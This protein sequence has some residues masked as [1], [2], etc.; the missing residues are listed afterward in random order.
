M[1]G[2]DRRLGTAKDDPWGSIVFL[3][4]IQ[5]QAGCRPVV[6]PNCIICVYTQQ[7]STGPLVQ[8]KDKDKHPSQ[9]LHCIEERE[10]AQMCALK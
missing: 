8:T 7:I 6:K 5:P 4:L 10:G 3:W 2:L 1:E 9:E